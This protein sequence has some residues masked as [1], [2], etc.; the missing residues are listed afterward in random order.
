M[1]NTIRASRSTFLPFLLS[2]SIT[3]GVFFFCDPWKKKEIIARRNN[4]NYKLGRTTYNLIMYMY[5]YVCYLWK[6]SIF[7]WNRIDTAIQ[8]WVVAIHGKVAGRSV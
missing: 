6:I 2:K 1:G 7:F 5:V 8:N 4:D 3:L